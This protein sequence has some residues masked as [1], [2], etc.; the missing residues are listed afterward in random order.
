VPDPA[1]PYRV[2]RLTQP[3]ADVAQIA[4]STFDGMLVVVEPTPT[5]DNEHTLRVTKINLVGDTL[6]SKSLPY[7]PVRLTAERVQQEIQRITSTRPRSVRDSSAATPLDA[8]A[9]E[10]AL[11]RPRY[12]PTATGLVI[13]ADGTILI[14]REDTN[15]ET[16][17]WTVMSRTGDLIAH[18]TTPSTTR[19]LAAGGPYMY[20]SERDS[21]GVITI[22]RY[23]AVVK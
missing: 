19:F 14:R 10:Q 7:T 1:A 11:Y 12:L 5:R 16:V 13:A 6:F 20:G 3:F 9:L 17:N 15:G 4:V 2:S 23:R 22:A 18:Q 21:T 8:R